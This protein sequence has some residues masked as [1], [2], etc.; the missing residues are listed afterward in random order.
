MKEAIS[1][2]NNIMMGTYI[3]IIISFGSLECN[4]KGPLLCT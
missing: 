2:N 1:Y 4:N 3:I